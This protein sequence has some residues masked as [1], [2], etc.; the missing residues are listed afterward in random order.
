MQQHLEFVVLLFGNLFNFIAGILVLTN[1]KNSY[2]VNDEI[3]NKNIYK[4][5]NYINITNY[6]DN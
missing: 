2:L 4:K 5:L 6:N 1:K 3:N